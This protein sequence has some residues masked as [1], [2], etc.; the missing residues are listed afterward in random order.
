MGLILY[1]FG[2][3]QIT[4]IQDYVV[5]M[6]RSSIHDFLISF[7]YFLQQVALMLYKFG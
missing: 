2:Q 4:V 1:A 6:I 3:F 5:Q 7:H